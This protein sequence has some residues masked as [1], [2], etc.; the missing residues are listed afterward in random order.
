MQHYSIGYHD[1]ENHHFEI[2][3]YAD[4]SFDAVQHAKEDVPYIHDHPN[5]IDRCT[6]ESGLDYVRQLGSLAYES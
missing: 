3:E 2:C 5:C 6:N 4:S 1:N